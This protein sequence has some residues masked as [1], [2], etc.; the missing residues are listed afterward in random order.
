MKTR[1]KRIKKNV[2]IRIYD[3]YIKLYGNIEGQKK[4]KYFTFA[5]ELKCINN[6]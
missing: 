2:D 1:I 6:A 5:N 3:N 4:Y